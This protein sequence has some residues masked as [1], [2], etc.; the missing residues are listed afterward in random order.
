M[1]SVKD[2]N[3]IPALTKDLNKTRRRKVK[4]GILE[5]MPFLVKIGVKNEFGSR[6]KVNDAMFRRL[7][8]LARE[9]GYPTSDLPKVGE[10]LIIPERSFMRSA[11]E[12]QA[13]A[14]ARMAAEKLADVA[15]G[16]K[17]DSYE[18]L[19]EAGRV[20]QRAILDK[21][22]AGGFEPNHPLTVAIKGHSRPLVGRTG[23]LETTQGIR[24]K[25][26]WV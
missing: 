11:F 2:T 25:V 3:R 17:E 4:V 15:A 10:T 19:Y 26:V 16:R 13:P 20:L 22:I 9:N 24:V 6:V 7:C 21:I 18:A 8:A 14:I 5:D 1:A 12:E 23:V